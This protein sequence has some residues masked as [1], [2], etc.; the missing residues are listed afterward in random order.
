MAQV[1]TNT[2]INTINILQEATSVEDGDLFLLQRGSST[3]KLKSIN[4]KIGSDNI[5]T[6]DGGNLTN[7]ITTINNSLTEI[8]EN[9][10]IITNNITG[11]KQ[12]TAAKK[13]YFT[14]RYNSNV[15]F[16][17]DWVARDIFLYK[18]YGGIIKNFNNS[19]NA[20]TLG[21]GTYEIFSIFPVTESGAFTA[22]FNAATNQVLIDIKG[23][24]ASSTNGHNFAS[25]NDSTNM[26]LKTLVSFDDD[27]QIVLKNKKY[28]SSTAYASVYHNLGFTETSNFGGFIEIQKVSDTYEPYILWDIAGNITTIAETWHVYHWNNDGKITLSLNNMSN[29]FTKSSDG[30]YNI[31][32]TRS[33]THS[34]ADINTTNNTASNL[35]LFSGLSSGSYNLVITDLN[36]TTYKS[37]SLTVSV[38]FNTTSNNVYTL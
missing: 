26:V 18:D 17:Y 36:A 1:T 23:H 5:I 32:I 19:S 14:S 6:G 9:T 35:I 37:K 12:S 8:T 16:G 21:R 33:D 20:F 10:G 4:L 28:N 22:L 29:S 15:I 11:V 34:F 25:G 31:R 3:L 13:A 27:T 7:N 24:T 30:T 2:E 38:G